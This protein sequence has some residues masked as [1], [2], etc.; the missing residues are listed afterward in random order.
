MTRW[1]SDRNS[2][3]RRCLRHSC[4]R[5]HAARLSVQ[6]TYAGYAKPFPEKHKR[7][8]SPKGC[9]P[10]FKP[11]LLDLDLGSSVLEKLLERFGVGLGNRLP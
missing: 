8:G 5:L 6:G 3:Y 4:L 9:Q 7:A 1:H 2:Q 10:S 11:E